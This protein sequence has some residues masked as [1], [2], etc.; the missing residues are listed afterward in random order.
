[1]AHE[2][3]A[4]LTGAAVLLALALVVTVVTRPRS[5]RLTPAPPTLPEVPALTREEVATDAR[6]HNPARAELTA[7]P[8]NP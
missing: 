2:L 4:A 3:S 7:A 1:L 8:P 5:R 6:A